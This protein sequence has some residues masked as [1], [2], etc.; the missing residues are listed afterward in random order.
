MPVLLGMARQRENKISFYDNSLPT[1][2]RPWH[3][4]CNNKAVSSS[5]KG[6]QALKGAPPPKMFVHSGRSG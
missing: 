1:N 5:F 3:G 2:N 4:G 6:T